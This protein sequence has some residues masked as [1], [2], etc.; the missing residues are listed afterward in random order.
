MNQ[1]D[2]IVRS[3]TPALGQEHVTPIT[4]QCDNPSCDNFGINITLQI[5]DDPA[6][7]ATWMGIICGVC[8]RLLLAGP[9]ST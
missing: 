3:E 4:V 5:N 2:P 9:A 8:T 1:E 7:L 6:V